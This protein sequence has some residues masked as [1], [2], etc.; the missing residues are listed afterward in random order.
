MDSRMSRRIRSWVI[1]VAVVMT[2]TSLAA[3]Q[4]GYGGREG[5]YREPIRAGLPEK[6]T[7]FMFCRLQYEYVVRFP[8]GY[9]WGTDYPRADRNFMTRLPQLTTAGVSAWNDGD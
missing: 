2:A 1:G 6:R 3:Q 4:R 9:G 7:G 5:Q 8:S